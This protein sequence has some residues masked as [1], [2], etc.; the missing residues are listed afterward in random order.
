[1]ISIAIGIL[2]FLAIQPEI[3]FSQLGAKSGL[4]ILTLNERWNG[5]DVQAFFK[6]R[7]PIRRRAIF[8]LFAGPNL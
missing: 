6:A 8:D 1:L 5:I 7:I 3:L 4:A 2:D